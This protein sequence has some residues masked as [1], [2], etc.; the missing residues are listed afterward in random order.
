MGQGCIFFLYHHVRNKLP[1]WF[2]TIDIISGDGID[3][4]IVKVSGGQTDTEKNDDWIYQTWL[5]VTLNKEVC[6][7]EIVHNYAILP[8]YR[9]KYSCKKQGDCTCDGMMCQGIS[10]EVGDGTANQKETDCKTGKTFKF[11]V[12][13]DGELG[14]GASND[15]YQKMI[16]SS[17]SG[18]SNT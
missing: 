2:K 1:Y 12:T 8:D 3:Q 11:M 6:V 14:M 7:N 13:T 18:K 10:V 9:N 16:I 15:V 4:L 17:P 5:Q